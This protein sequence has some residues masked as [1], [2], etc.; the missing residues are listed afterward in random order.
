MRLTQT[1][2]RSR[3]V[4]ALASPHG[5]D[6]YLEQANPVWAAHEVGP[7]SSTSIVRSTWRATR[8]SRRS[9]CSRPASGA[10]T[11]PASG[12]LW[13]VARKICRFALP[14]RRTPS[15]QPEPVAEPA[16]AA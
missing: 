4:A 6:R 1:L 16:A 9:R 2:L 12:Q 15:Q 3:A 13:S 5:V 14:D 11:G 10:A 8:R 7:R